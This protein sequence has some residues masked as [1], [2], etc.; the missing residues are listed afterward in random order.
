MRRPKSKSPLNHMP[1]VR[2]SQDFGLLAPPEYMCLR[3]IRLAISSFG[4][5]IARGEARM[6]SRTS[7]FSVAVFLMLTTATVANVA[8]GQDNAA[9]TAGR[10]AR[11][12]VAPAYPPLAKQLNVSGKV[13]LEVTVSADGRVTAT[14]T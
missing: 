14:K 5:S 12:K 7:A 4:S 8:D 6:R 9:S 1:S 2:C 3:G 13:K 10:K 11:T